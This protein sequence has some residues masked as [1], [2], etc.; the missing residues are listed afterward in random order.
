MPIG[1]AREIEPSSGFGFD[2]VPLGLGAVAIVLFVVGI[3]VVATAVTAG[4]R[5]HATRTKPAR[6]ANAA[7]R[8]GFSPTAVSGARFALERGRGASVVPVVSSFVGLTIAVA[9]VVGSLTFGAGLTH[10]RSTPRLVGWNWDVALTYP[11]E[12]LPGEATPAEA[13][14]LVR[15]AFAKIH[16]DDT[17]MA[18]IWSP[19]PQGRDLQLGPDH[20]GAGGFIAFDGTARVGPSVISG[21]KPTGA[22]EIL[23][24]PRTLEQL[25]VHVGDDIEV[26]GQEGTWDAPGR[27][28]TTRMRI[29]G[30]GIAPMTTALGRGAVI[31]LAGVQRL[32]SQAREQAWFVRLPPGADKQAAVDAFASL[33]PGEVRKDISSVEFEQVGDSGLSLEQIGSVPLLFAV[34]MMLMAAAVLARAHRHAPRPRLAVLR[35]GLL[36]D[37]S[38]GRSRG[39]R[40]SR[41][42]RLAIGVPLASR[43]DS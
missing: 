21:R 29:V 15:A 14:Q 11:E 30:T 35:A 34:I 18:M 25:G 9:A 38:C 28:T 27:E 23:L 2:P 7:A 19:F 17:G 37:R 8:A 33:F 42:R 4:R 12:A 6:L 40:R 20:V 32:N 36:A 26:V 22:D 5:E 13:Q 3:T 1:L 24:G 39:N 10:L 41:G 43:W 16:V 31:T